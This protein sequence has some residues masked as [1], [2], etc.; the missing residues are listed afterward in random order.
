MT[1]RHGDLAFND[2]DTTLSVQLREN[3]REIE[4]E[5]KGIALIALSICHQHHVKGWIHIR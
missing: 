1:D 4:Q 5:F 2:A 3:E